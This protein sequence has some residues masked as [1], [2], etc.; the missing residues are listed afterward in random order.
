MNPNIWNF[1]G[2]LAAILLL[3]LLIALVFGEVSL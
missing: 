2:V 1:V 3:L